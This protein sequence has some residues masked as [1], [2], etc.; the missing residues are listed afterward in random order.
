MSY[1]EL[2]LIFLVIKCLNW[3]FLNST[4]RTDN[5]RL[6]ALCTALI[7]A[8]EMFEWFDSLIKKNIWKCTCIAIRCLCKK[9]L[10]QTIRHLKMVKS[11]KK[12]SKLQ[13]M[14]ETS[15]V[16]N[17]W[18]QFLWCIDLSKEQMRLLMEFKAAL[19]VKNWF[20]GNC[21]SIFIS[22]N[23]SRNEWTQRSTNFYPQRLQLHICFCCLN[24]FKPAS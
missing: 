21:C 22:F 5:I 11:L 6:Y 18:L 7:R 16:W 20:D 10:F 3:F 2:L 9:W 13:S 17:W 14:D 15:L 12:I 1:F 4:T 23:D 24:Y 19:S 8:L